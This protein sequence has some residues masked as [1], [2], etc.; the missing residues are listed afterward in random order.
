MSST[1]RNVLGQSYDEEIAG[2]A[3]EGFKRKRSSPSIIWP[4]LVFLPGDE[5]IV[6]RI[7]VSA[8]G[9]SV[10]HQAW[11]WCFCY[12]LHCIKEKN[13]TQPQLC[14]QLLVGQLVSR[15]SHSQRC[16]PPA[17]KLGAGLPSSSC[18]LLPTCVPSSLSNSP[19]MCREIHCALRCII[20]AASCHSP[21]LGSK[22]IVSETKI[23]HNVAVRLLNLSSES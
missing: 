6:A 18:T 11:W 5:T 3:F 4:K 23:I 14:T 7:M 15:N 1:C 16:C 17:V 13:S 10:R 2:K 21:T 19:S 8:Q 20:S 12:P 22:P 9:S